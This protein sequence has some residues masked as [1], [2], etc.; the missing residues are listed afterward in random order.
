MN[1]TGLVKTLTY[2]GGTDPEI[3]GSATSGYFLPGVTYN[4]CVYFV[5]PSALTLTGNGN[6]TSTT[7]PTAGTVLYAGKYSNAL[8][9]ATVGLNVFHG[10]DCG[11]G[12]DF[13]TDPSYTT[14][15]A[16][17]N[18][19]KMSGTTPAMV[20]TRRGRTSGATSPTAS[21]STSVWTGSR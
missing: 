15:D 20:S 17:G 19:S 9:N 13:Y 10:Y 21:T 1:P 14:T 6:A 11:T 12:Q 4:V 5:H 16:S 3:T 7:I 8:P 2:V 18:Y